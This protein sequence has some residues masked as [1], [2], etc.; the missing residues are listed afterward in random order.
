MP[1]QFRQATSETL[2]TLQEQFLRESLPAQFNTQIASLRN[3]GLLESILK[4]STPADDELVIELQE[5]I[6]GM[7]G[8]PYP[9]PTVEE[10]A[11]HFSQE[12]YAEK[13]SQGFTKLLIVPF[14]YPL[15]TICARYEQALLKHHKAGK[16]LDRDG[17][18]LILDTKRPL[19]FLKF[20]NKSDETGDMIYYPKQFDTENHGG[21]TKQELLT[22]VT[23]E[24]KFNSPFLGFHIL[25]IKPDLTIPR[26]GMTQTTG[27]RADL[28]SVKSPN[29][30]LYTIQTNSFYNHE[31]GMTLEDS[32]IL[33]LTNLHETNRVI[34]DFENIKDSVNFNIGVFHKA[35]GHVPISYWFLTL[36]RADIDMRDPK[37]SYEDSGCRVAVS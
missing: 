30:Y 19:Y 7:D 3:V 11:K 2:P 34:D 35:S 23:Q 16:L 4:E 9:L 37:S 6:T 5:G 27:G 20:L 25:L 15:A 22:P 1:E 32:L 12:K 31:Q 13:I 29:N 17:T 33:A 18:L 36:G 24:A 21:F 28:E 8:R 26:K 14:A 10:I